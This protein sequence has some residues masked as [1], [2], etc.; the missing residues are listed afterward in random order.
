M[1]T[2]FLVW[3]WIIFFFQKRIFF[4]SVIKFGEPVS[5]AESGI[6]N[7][8]LFWF[9]FFFK[10]FTLNLRLESIRL[11]LK[12]R[13]LTRVGHRIILIAKFVA[14]A[15]LIHQV[16]ENLVVDTEFKSLSL[17]DN[18]DNV[19]VDTEWVRETHESD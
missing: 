9:R 3:K 19:V 7:M 11:F 5:K 1:F 10:A 18:V 8:F 6:K 13:I 2:M 15:F 14:R 12:A 17:L 16:W 4:M